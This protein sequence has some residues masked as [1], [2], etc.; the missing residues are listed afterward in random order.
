LRWIPLLVLGKL[1]VSF[2]GGW[3]SCDEQ[4]HRGRL[5]VEPNT[6]NRAVEYQPDDPTPQRLAQFGL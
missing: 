5:S 4:R 2:S 1:M 3:H 6:Y